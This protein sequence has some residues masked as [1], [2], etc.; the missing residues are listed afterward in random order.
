MG[1]LH[2]KGHKGG[3]EG[4]RERGKEPAFYTNTTL[5]LCIIG[6]CKFES[7]IN[8]VTLLRSNNKVTGLPVLP[9]IEL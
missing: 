9:H 7:S 6:Y 3:A 1:I 4:E 8:R 2:I 5:I